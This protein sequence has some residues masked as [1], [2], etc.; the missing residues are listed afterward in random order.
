V[1]ALKAMIPKTPKSSL[2]SMCNFSAEDSHHIPIKP[3]GD[4]A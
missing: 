1:K 4:Q 3:S 2:V